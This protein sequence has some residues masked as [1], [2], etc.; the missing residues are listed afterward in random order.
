MIAAFV[1]RF[2]GHFLVV[3]L[4]LSADAYAKECVVLLHGLARS[5]TSMEALEERLT[6]TNYDV[7]NVDYPS[8]E[9]PIEQL[10]TLAIEQALS[11]CQM[12]QAF[13]V[14]FVTHSLGGLLVR[15]YYSHNST[16]GLGRV[17]MLGPP[18]QGSQVVDH[19]RALPGFEFVNGPSGMQLGT[20]A[21][22]MPRQ[23]GPVNFELAVIAGTQS[24]NLFLSLFLPN[25][26]DGK[27]SVANTKVKGMC[28]FVALPTTHPFMMKNNVVIN[29]V[30]SFL[31]A[32]RF[33]HP[34]AVNISAANNC[35][36]R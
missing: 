28:S 35:G 14:H 23:L 29:E 31:Q 20:D 8:R 13:P 3:F 21:D 33:E 17:V 32:G 7:V 5:S 12:Q 15:Y 22:G 18:N 30:V 27:V 6:S 1:R 11:S 26:D 10:S 9:M 2:C 25:P 4:L 34:D 16:N 36:E 19:L 24:M